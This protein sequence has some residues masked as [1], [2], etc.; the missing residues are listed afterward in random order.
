VRRPG[1]DRTPTVN[2][3]NSL[4]EESIRVSE[5]FGKFIGNN[6]SPTEF[7]DGMNNTQTFENMKKR[8]NTVTGI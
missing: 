3:V 6:R 5:D 8:I 2:T 4:K 1:A 7:D